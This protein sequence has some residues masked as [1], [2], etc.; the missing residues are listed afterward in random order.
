MS[1]KLKWHLLFDIFFLL[2]F[3]E[4]IIQLGKG[5]RV[6]LKREKEYIIITQYKLVIKDLIITLY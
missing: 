5:A 6:I 1:S 2:F 4:N 3:E